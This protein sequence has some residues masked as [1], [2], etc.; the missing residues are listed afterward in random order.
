MAISVWP[1]YVQPGQLRYSKEEKEKT[2]AD[3]CHVIYKLHGDFFSNPALALI[4]G[5][6]NT[7]KKLI[8]LLGLSIIHLVFHMCMY[9]PE[10]RPFKTAPETCQPNHACVFP[11]S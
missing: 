4:Y 10:F 9:S 2:L 8:V 11:G 7:V 5:L 6:T 3:F 1:T